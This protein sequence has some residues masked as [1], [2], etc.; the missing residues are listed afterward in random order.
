MSELKTFTIAQFSGVNKSETETLLQLG[1]AS[2]MSNFMITDDMKLKKQYGYVHMNSEVAGKKVNGVWCG[3]LNGVNYFLF[4]RGGK[5]YELNLST[6]AE[7][8]LGTIVEA[9]P[10]TF[11]VTNN[12]VY[13]MDGTDLYSWDTVTF[14]VVPGY[15][16]TV[17]TA[18]P[19]YG[20]GMLLEGI[21]YLTGKKIM[22]FSADGT[23]TVYQLSETVIDSVD[24]VV[25]VGGAAQVEGTD[26]TVDLAAG[27]VAFV[28]PPA[29][30]VN[31]I[32]IA[33]TKE[34]PGDRQAITGNKHY[35]G[36]Y[37][38]RFWIFGNP[39]HRNTRYC[40]GVTM[41]GTSDPTYW[42]KWA[43]SDVGEFAI[44]D[45]KTQYDKQLIWT[46]GDSSG[47]SAWYS[48]EEDYTDPNTGIVSAL[49]PVYPINAK[50]GNVA[51]GQVQI[52]LNSPFT[53]YKG[54]FK[55][56]STYVMNE[57]NAEW[58]S[59]KV[60]RDLDKL[61]LAKA[62]T[63]DWDDKGLYYL[64]IGKRIWVYNY[65]V[66]AWY[67]LDLPHE[68]TCFIAAEKELYIGTPDGQIMRFDETAATYDGEIINA[69]WYMGLG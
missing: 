17:F 69:Y 57:K 66:D 49:F 15:V 8:E 5:V 27:R 25:I 48:M 13:I 12:T 18:A 28:S 14:Q 34:T 68:P 32:V 26:Y 21:N 45:I 51:P 50:V 7:T 62:I 11:F 3:P 29:E 64:A 42:P 55:W 31:N 1:E 30:G 10:T 19:P 46:T 9:Y 67:I 20:G 47:A 53:V 4:A 43:E 61:D 33:W 65:R 39:S 24:S 37:Y 44:T 60:Q 52:I 58:I 38:A 22:K 56:V 35:G 40:S 2:E 6:G 59:R 36:Q 23:A 63:W 54:V 41:A 16:P